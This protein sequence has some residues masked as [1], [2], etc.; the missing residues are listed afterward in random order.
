MSKKVLVLL[1]SP[2]AGGSSE[3]LAKAF[4]KGAQERGCDVRE[5]RLAP[6]CLN[7]CLGCRRCWTTGN[8]CIQRD[9]MDE[10]YPLLEK[11]DAIV[12]VSPLF[13]Y[14]WTA[15]IKPVI[16]RMFA[17]LGKD[18]P[19]RLSG[20]QTALLTVCGDAEDGAFA[21]LSASDRI[22]ADYMKWEN[23]GEVYAS[24]IH[25]PADMDAHGAPK[26]SEA[27]ALGGRL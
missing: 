22:L 21:G 24:G 16:D 6:L 9:D 20:K 10:I 8:P 12:F 7:G 26:L 13:F 23:I 2:H 14:S 15:Q 17:F 18:S 5:V 27:E 11:A 25:T 19:V 3:K 4:E 1:G